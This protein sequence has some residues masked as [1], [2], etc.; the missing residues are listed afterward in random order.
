MIVETVPGR[1][2]GT[3]GRGGSTAFLGVPYATAE[4]FGAP[5]PAEPWPG[6]RDALEPGPAA[7]QGPS[8]LE[9]IMGPVA[10]AQSEDCLT[11]NVWTPSAAGPPRPVLVFLHGGGYSSGSGGFPWYDGG[12]LA[13]RGG[14]VVVTAS[15][16][17]G[18]LGFLR[19][20]GVSEGNLGLRDQL[21]ALE[22]VRDGIAAFGGDPGAVTVAGQSAG[23]F[24][25][26]ALLSTG[27]AR[28]LFHRA[29]L[30]SNPGGM[31]PTA[32]ADAER[33]GALYRELLGADPRTAPVGALLAAQGEL[34][35]RTVRPLDAVPPFQL[36][37]DG[38]LVADDPVTA[39]GRRGADGVDVLLGTN[40]DEAAAFF[41]GDDR[42]AALDRDALAAAATRWF[43]APDRALAPRPVPELAVELATDHLFREPAD[44]LSALLAEHGDPPWTYRFDWQPPGSP[45]GACHCVEL[46]F[47]FGDPEPWRDAPMLGGAPPPPS[48]VTEMQDAWTGFVHKGTPGWS[49]GTMRHF[50]G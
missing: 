21:A 11:L 28:G 50:T 40:R 24:S 29:I 23:A 47:V 25:I 2:R 22:W 10:A 35:R 45:F 37:A 44:R 17:L 20:P 12:V 36:V 16:R 26:M 30:Q 8:R 15:Y 42:I 4:R 3:A 48:L 32:P 14:M 33:T 31:I 34:A 46:P 13:A 39:A 27:R 43:G 7:P 9:R 19:L 49:R 18:A 41:A 5:R 38:S 6:V 1:V